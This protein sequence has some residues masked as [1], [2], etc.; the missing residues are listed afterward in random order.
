MDSKFTTEPSTVDE[1]IDRRRKSKLGGSGFI[2]G[3]PGTGSR[4]VALDQIRSIL[5]N[6]NDPVILIDT[7]GSF[8]SFAA[9]VDS[10][11]IKPFPGGDVHI[12]PFD[13]EPEHPVDDVPVAQKSNYI[14]ALMQEVLGSQ[15][16]LSPLQMSILDHCVRKA[17]SPY[18]Q[19]KNEE[20]GEHDPDLLPTLGDFQQCLKSEGLPDAEK[21]ADVLECYV[22]GPVDL[23][24]FPTNIHH[25]KQ[26]I[27]YDISSL[28]PQLTPIFLM[29]ILENVWTRYILSRRSA[30]DRNIAWIF[31]TDP[32]WLLHT[33]H[34]EG[35]LKE[36][37]KRARL[38]RCIFTGVTNH[39][40]LFLTD[41]FRYML[42]NC[43][44][45]HMLKMDPPER[46]CFASLLSLS[47]EHEAFLA[48]LRLGKTLVYM[49]GDLLA[50]DAIHVLKRYRWDHDSKQYVEDDSE[51][52][53]TIEPE[54]VFKQYKM[55]CKKATVTNYILLGLSVLVLVAHFVL[56]ANFPSLLSTIEWILLFL[57]TAGIAYTMGFFAIKELLKT[58]DNLRKIMIGKYDIVEDV[59]TD[60]HIVNGPFL[61]TLYIV[62]FEKYA[63]EGRT[64]PY[65]NGI[66][67]SRKSFETIRIG[68][69]KQY[70]ILHENKGHISCFVDLGVNG[71]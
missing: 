10:Q 59:V 53:G 54:A 57:G 49:D 6:S 46:Q 13:I 22:S 24:A 31:I 62:D 34:S 50:I 51:G 47:P 56:H 35:F 1:I 33:A 30:D 2:L 36:C 12:N 11:I 14:I 23:F 45:L 17:Y 19:S 69:K 25:E 65:K 44:Y 66:P 43:G 41:S 63:P 61:S 58:N 7:D 38:M 64:G 3:K 21:L 32:Y 67:V 9:S 39:V 71:S 27:V 15:N 18:L 42:A 4:L 29:A 26:L 8:S 52:K 20:T 37:Y 60:K 55:A 5:Q 40:A 70:L 48:N 68:D 16:A 28:T